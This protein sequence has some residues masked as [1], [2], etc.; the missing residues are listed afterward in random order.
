M[1]LSSQR[2]PE[3]IDGIHLTAGER[4][5]A[6]GEGREGGETKGF[7]LLAPAVPSRC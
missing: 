4:R 3:R 2:M 5:E 7:L 6:R 1:G